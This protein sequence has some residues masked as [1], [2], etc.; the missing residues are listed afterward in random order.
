MLTVSV[1][2]RKMIGAANKSPPA[3]HP[4][5]RKDPLVKDSRDRERQGVR[6]HTVAPKMVL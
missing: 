4:H 2:R 5:W 1:M 3:R 6:S